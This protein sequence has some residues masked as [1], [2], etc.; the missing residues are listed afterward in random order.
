MRAKGFAAVVMVLAGLAACGGGGGDTPVTPT[1][2][3]KGVEAAGGDGQVTLSWT[4]S[5]GATSYNAYWSATSGVTKTSGTQIPGVASPYAHLNRTNGTT[6]FYVVTAVN[7]A[8][9]SAASAQASATPTNVAT[10]VQVEATV[11]RLWRDDGYVNLGWSVSVMN[12]GIPVN[13][14]IVSVNG[15]NLPKASGFIDGWYALLDSDS[16]RPTYVPGLE[17]VVS[18]Q[19]NGTTY[20]DSM[21]TPGDFMANADYTQV[22]WA[23]DGI[24]TGLE[25]RHLFGS[26]TYSAPPS[27]PAALTSPQV[28]PASA[29]PS[30]G[31]YVISIGTQNIKNHSF[32][33][34]RGENCYL[35]VHDGRE[36][37]I[38]K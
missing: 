25:V 5:T 7:S 16:P 6:Y 11:D 8:G 27:S 38:V 33:S 35:N 15:I 9:E 14:A 1:S 31:T 21:T 17:Y 22:Q 30:P 12:N 26:T 3:P 13:N 32:G 23:H 36:W 18:V 34:L 37:R 24:Y 28:I 19:L 10:P 4:A 20:T 29:Y 2:A